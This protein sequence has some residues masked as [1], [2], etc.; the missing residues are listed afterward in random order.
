[1]PDWLKKLEANATEKRGESSM[2]AFLMDD[3]SELPLDTSAGAGEESTQAGKTEEEGESPY[4]STLPEWISQVSAESESPEGQPAEEEQEPGLAP[5]QLPT[6]LEAMRPVEAAAPAAPAGEDL[7]AQVEKVGPL[8]GLRG[9]IPAEPVIGHLRKPPAYSVK[10]QVSE[11]QHL[12][13][14]ILQRLLASEGEAKPV[15]PRGGAAS[16]AVVRLVIAVFLFLAVLVPLWLNT[17][18]L[19]LPDPTFIPTGVMETNNLIN[20]LNSGEPVL[21]GIDYEPGLSAEMDATAKTIVK[22][23]TSRG[24]TLALVSTNPIGPV[25]AERLMSS[26]KADQT[27]VNLGFIA[28]GPAGLLSFAEAPKAAMPYDL[29]SG[30]QP[31]RPIYGR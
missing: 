19:P 7:S 14:V 20:S 25:I 5:A 1:M 16:Q 3:E 31:P 8:A 22:Q 9:V 10:L 6:W 11:S 4:L 29:G 17:Q 15:S 27:Y 30:G 26:V 24:I 23:L 2:P 28:G 18:N 21:L 12:N 13:S